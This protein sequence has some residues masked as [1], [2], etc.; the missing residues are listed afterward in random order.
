MQISKIRINPWLDSYLVHIR[1]GLSLNAEFS[2]SIHE[3]SVLILY[4][5]GRHGLNI[6]RILRGEVI[7]RYGL[8]HIQSK[9]YGES[10]LT[11]IFRISQWCCSIENFETTYNKHIK[12]QRQNFILV[13][14]YLRK[15][16]WKCLNI[17]KFDIKVRDPV[18][19]FWLKLVFDLTA[20]I[21]QNSPL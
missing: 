21:G 20:N 1:T 4:Y 6:D 18:I 16:R 5:M 2:Y 17:L 3:T 13:R 12:E 10:L 11:C 19:W 15:S 8:F 9:I 14:V 7:I